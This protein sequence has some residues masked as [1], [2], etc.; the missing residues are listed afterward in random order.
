MN[1]INQTRFLWSAILGLA[2]V[3]ATSL[4]QGLSWNG[5]M[6]QALEPER[7][8]EVER[9]YGR[10]NLNGASTRRAEVGDR[11]SQSGQGVSTG[12]WSSSILAIDSAIG[13]VQVAQNTQFR[14]DELSV[15]S[16]GARV[17]LLDVTQGQVRVQARRF[18]NPNSRLE[19]RTPSGVAAVRGTDFGVSIQP[20]G[21]MAIAT[22]SGAVEVGASDMGTLEE[23]APNADALASNPSMPDSGQ[24]PTSVMIYPGYMTTLVDGGTPTPPRLI[25]RRLDFEVLRQ[26]KI[27]GRIVIKANVDPA[28]SVLFNGEEV[29]MDKQGNL[30][31]Y[32]GH[33][34]SLLK[35]L[36][37]NP[38]G[39]S[40]EHFIWIDDD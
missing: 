21:V 7:W 36:V 19:V 13:R 24:S 22:E 8:L 37:R 5:P 25:D 39:E 3:P 31:S 4:F 40:R 12:R 34:H 32:L 27:G 2:M 1:D 15:L 28:N 30:V 23:A 38:L 35:V 6:A 20:N 16:D 33:H 9:I 14:V 10:V 29:V 26:G 18:T 11:L 17:T